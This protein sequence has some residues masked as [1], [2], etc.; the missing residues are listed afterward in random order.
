MRVSEAL[1]AVCF[2]LFFQ[3]ALS[4][5]FD[6]GRASTVTEKMV[7]NNDRLSS[8]DTELGDLF[9]LVVADAIASQ[10]QNLIAEQRVWISQIRNSCRDEDCLQSAYMDRLRK[11]SVVDDSNG[12]E[13]KYVFATGEKSGQLL[14]FQRALRQMDVDGPL[15][16]CTRMIRLE[17]SGGAQV[18][19]GSLPEDV[20]SASCELH[21]HPVMICDNTLTGQLTV[22]F[23]GVAYGKPLVSFAS[24]NCPYGG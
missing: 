10:K 18:T 9:H 14:E 1:I 5:S 2:L 6:C 11:L 24:M 12:S 16:E 23:A 15:T 19:R 7:C 4:A 17:Q 21:G 8:L 13:G 22:T 3:P 20:Y